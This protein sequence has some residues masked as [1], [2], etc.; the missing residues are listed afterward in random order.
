M[1]CFEGHH[2]TTLGE[3]TNSGGHHV[4]VCHPHDLHH[5][6]TS[7]IP[8]C[9]KEL[10]CNF[11]TIF[12]QELDSVNKLISDGKAKANDIRNNLKNLEATSTR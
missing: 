9:L 4:Q 11:K 12:F 6:Q 2:V 7:D 5:I 3:I 10:C 8:M 1:H